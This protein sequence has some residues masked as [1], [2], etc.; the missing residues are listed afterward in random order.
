MSN[1]VLEEVVS[2]QRIEKLESRI[3]GLVAFTGEYA[4]KLK[5]A[6]KAAITTTE[7]SI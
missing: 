7:R 5:A 1:D 4:E 3:L 2:M 6:N